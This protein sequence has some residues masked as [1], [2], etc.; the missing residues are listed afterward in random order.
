MF[1]FSLKVPFPG[2]LINFSQQLMNYYYKKKMLTLV[3]F[4]CLGGL[5]N[6]QKQLKPFPVHLKSQGK[7]QKEEEEGTSRVGIR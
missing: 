6:V 5:R 4:A 2:K 7:A 3:T 1:G